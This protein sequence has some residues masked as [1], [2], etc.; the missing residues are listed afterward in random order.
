MYIYTIYCNTMIKENLSYSSFNTIQYKTYSQAV[1]IHLNVLKM[2]NQIEVRN[3]YS[4][5][6]N[7]ATNSKMH[8]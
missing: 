1:L 4:K 8:S 6:F 3:M 7:K 5:K 2:L